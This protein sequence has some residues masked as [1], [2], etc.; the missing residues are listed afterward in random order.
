MTIASSPPVP[1]IV[2]VAIVSLPSVSW[3]HQNPRGLLFAPIQTAPA[4][5]ADR[6]CAMSAEQH[7]AR[8]DDGAVHEGDDLVRCAAVE[9]HLPV[10]GVDVGEGRAR[11]VTDEM[12]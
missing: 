12:Q 5:G 9:I 10:G 8:I 7:I 2:K 1:S 4:S 6:A 11:A 3:V